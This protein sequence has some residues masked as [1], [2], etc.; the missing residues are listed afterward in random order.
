MRLH[1]D[2]RV[3]VARG[4]ELAAKKDPV[5]AIDT[6]RVVVG[7]TRQFLEMQTGMAGFASKKPELFAGAPGKLL[8]QSLQ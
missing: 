8:R 7:P 2:D 1:V 3:E 6:D 5:S 4:I